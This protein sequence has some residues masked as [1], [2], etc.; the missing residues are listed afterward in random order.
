MDRPEGWEWLDEPR[1][2]WETPDLLRGPATSAPTNLAIVMLSCDFLGHELSALVGR[3]V[4]EY[5]LFYLR[6]PG[7]GLSFRDQAQI[8]DV[9]TKHT[10]CIFEAWER[11]RTG[12]EQNSPADEIRRL[13]QENR[14]ALANE[15]NEAISAFSG[16]PGSIL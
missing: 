14:E 9:L 3:F 2:R 8:S 12:A 13:M 16:L 6:P 1:E 5:A 15:L 11:F 4:T 7:R 10:R